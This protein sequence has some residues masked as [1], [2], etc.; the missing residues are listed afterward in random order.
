MGGGGRRVVKE[1]HS[2]SA[3]LTSDHC[4]ILPNVHTFMPFT[5]SHSDGAVNQA[6]RQPARQ[7]PSGWG[8]LAQGHL[9]TP[10]GGAGDRTS[11]LPVTSQPALLPDTHPAQ[12]KHND[13]IKL[14]SWFRS[15]GRHPEGI[16]VSIFKIKLLHIL[17]RKLDPNVSLAG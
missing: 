6:G 2:Y 8:G 13:R 7:E 16:P 10:L 15:A 12:I 1:L 3:A 4:T 14:I 9:R 17:L 11:N 5:H